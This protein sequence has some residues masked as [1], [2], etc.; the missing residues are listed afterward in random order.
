MK[1][2]LL[3]YLKAMKL[4]ERTADLTTIASKFPE[5]ELSKILEE[6]CSEGFIYEP[7]KGVW[8]WLG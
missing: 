1:T 8:K 6:L 3:N 4:A 2:Q 7:C 5:A